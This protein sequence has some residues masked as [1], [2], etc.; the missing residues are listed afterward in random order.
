MRSEQILKHHTGGTARCEEGRLAAG[1]I[2]EGPPGLRQ[3]KCYQSSGRHSRAVQK[4]V[5]LDQ[6]SSPHSSWIAIAGLVWF[7][8]SRK[9]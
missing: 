9:E 2:S 5:I 7:E 3:E 6:D 8:A 4:H 1:E